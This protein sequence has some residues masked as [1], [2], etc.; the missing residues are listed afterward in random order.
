MK[1]P[2]VQ[3]LNS[4]LYSIFKVLALKITKKKKKKKKKERKKDAIGFEHV[5]LTAPPDR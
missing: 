5:F 1:E 4:H 2:K 3:H